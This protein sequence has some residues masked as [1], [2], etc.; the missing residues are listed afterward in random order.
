MWEGSP[1]FENYAVEVAVLQS[2]MAY[3]KL[4]YEASV[5]SNGMCSL[6]VMKIGGKC[7]RMGRL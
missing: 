2:K 3:L 5:S 6:V 4:H 1:R 7:W